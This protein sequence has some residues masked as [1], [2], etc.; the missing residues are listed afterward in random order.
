MAN[1]VVRVRRE[2][3][4]EC[5]RCPLCNKLFN[6][7]T[8]IS[9]CL[10]T[11]CRKCIYQKLADEESD[12][13]PVCNIDL[14]TAPE[15]KLRPDHSLQDLRAKIFP[16][17]RRKVELHE[18]VPS[19]SL[20]VKRKERSLKSLVVNTPRISTQTGLTR[21]RTKAFARK[22]AA[23]IN[24]RFSIEEPIRILEDRQENSLSPETFG[25]I[26]NK[27]ISPLAESSNHHIPIKD[28]EKGV[29][30]WEGKADLWKPLSCLV[31]AANRTK[32]NSKDAASPSEVLVP[33]KKVG[34][35]LRKKIHDEK[36]VTTKPKKLSRM[37]RKKELPISPQLV[38]DARCVKP[39]RRASPI[40]LTLMASKE[41]EGYAPLPQISTSYLRIKDGHLP[42][43]VIQKYLAK[44]LD[45]NEAE[46]EIKC[47]DQPVVPTLILHDLIDTWVR[48]AW[49]LSRVPTYVGSSAKDFVMVLAYS[50]KKVLVP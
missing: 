7:A 21:K 43:S 47:R 2:C 49:T 22:R 9:E 3:L 37:G 11:F 41:Q 5:M 39:D 12:C 30:P 44:K 14:G 16:F 46:V 26:A 45:L 17:K 20:P 42:V 19:S 25:K 8:T 38:L 40:W 50:R 36:D 4:G 48:T 35:Y 24:S 34:K 18:D 28:T 31:E 15:E 33:R 32:C 10:H 29:E 23:L 27:Q 1:Q 6:Q 13:C